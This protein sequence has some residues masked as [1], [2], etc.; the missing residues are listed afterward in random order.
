[1][2]EEP[3]V[4]P[5]PRGPD[6]VRRSLSWTLFGELSFAAAQ[7]AALMVIA[8]LG[9]AEALGRYSLGLA[10][11]TPVIVFANLHLRP[12]YVVDVRSRW[13]FADYL[14]LRSV[15]LP[16]A[17]VVVAI[18][19]LV[20]GWPWQTAAVVMLIGLIHAS[21]SASDLYYARAQRAETMDPIGVSRAVRG[22]LWIGLLALGLVVF[23]DDVLALTLVAVAHLVHTLLYDRR[24]AAGVEITADPTGT[25]MRPRFDGAALRGLF[26]TALPMG[27]AGGLLGLTSNIPAYVLED[28]HGLAA[29]GALA[30]VLS[31]RQ[32]SG[33]INMALGNAAI[34]RLAKL[35]VDD[36]RGFWRLLAKLLALVLVLNGIGV[37]LVALLGGLYLRYGYTPEYEVYLPQLVLASIAAVVLGLA[38]TLSQTLTALSYFRLQLWINLASVLAT[39]GATLWLV[40]TRGIDG[41]VEAIL[42]IACLR[43]VIYIG[44]NLI[45]GPR[46]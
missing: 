8:K 21:G 14:G 23:N 4:P 26:R 46:A 22:L 35:S 5:A 28:T 43:L 3:P 17:I 13:G 18:A 9:S 30:A 6:S 31:I 42:A 11:A 19:C 32:A 34:A 45:L 44:A 7:W 25:R 41:A 36:A 2:S 38:N 15:L 16:L 37:A 1:V 40:P 20:R 29:V 24:K 27:L 39:I 33:V 10:V 12:I